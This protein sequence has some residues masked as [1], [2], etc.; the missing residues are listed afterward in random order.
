MHVDQNPFFK[1]GLKCVQGMIPL[2]NVRKDEVGGLQV[3]A[4]TNNSKTQQYLSQNYPIT[5][6]NDSEWL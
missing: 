6:V 4:K 3:V 1:K 2:R 5:T